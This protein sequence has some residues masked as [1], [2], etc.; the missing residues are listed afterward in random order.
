MAAVTA[1]RHD[2][3]TFGVAALAYALPERFVELRELEALGLLESGAEAMERFGFGGAHVSDRPAHE[4]ALQALRRLIDREHLDPD[5]IDLLLF[6]GALPDSHFVQAGGTL[7]PFAYPA[8]RLQYETGLT[9]ATTIGIGQTGCTG[10]MTGVALAVDFLRSHPEAR[11]ALVVSADVLP[12]SLPR[13]IVYNVIS[14]GACAL[15][16]ER[17]A[18]RNRV[19]G[20]RKVQKGYYWD[21]GARRNELVAAYFPTARMLVDDTLR[22][23]GLTK[24]DVALVL[25]HNVSLRSWQILL[26]ILGLPLDRLFADN[27][28]AKGHVI[29]ADNFINLQDA[30]EQGRIRTG[31]RLLLFTFGFGASWACLALEA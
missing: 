31:D 7:D 11:R 24:D 23:L 19:L 29:A 28:G 21:A 27:I 14:D 17:D 22:V 6:A 30:W 10:L 16:V 13:E 26:P 25:P 4:L 5:T 20:F 15:L 9:R 3:T 2:R 12:P 1:H 18:S 8:S